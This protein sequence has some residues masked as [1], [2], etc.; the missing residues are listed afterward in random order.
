MFFGDVVCIHQINKR[1]ILNKQT[2]K[3]YAKGR[4]YAKTILEIQ[5]T[6]YFWKNTVL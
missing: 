2:P 5:A 6:S 3:Y 4:A 1:I